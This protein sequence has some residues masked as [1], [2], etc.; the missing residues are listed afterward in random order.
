VHLVYSEYA[1]SKSDALR[2]EL[3]IKS[4][5]RS[6]KLALINKENHGE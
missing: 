2:R 4:L 1:G 3:Q 5:T 6:Q